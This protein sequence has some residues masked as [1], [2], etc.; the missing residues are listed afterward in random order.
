[1]NLR[2]SGLGAAALLFALSLASSALAQS[3]SIVG[4]VPAVENFDSLAS[5]G[6][7]DVLPPGW[8]FVESGTNANTTYAADNGGVNSGNTYS[9]GATGS[10]ERALGGLLSGSL[11][12][13]FGARLRN[14]SGSTLAEIAIEYTGEQWRLGALGREDRLD[15]QYSLDATSLATGTWTDV[16]ALDFVAP[17]TA[18]SIGALNGNDAAN[19]RLISG[20]ITGLNLAPEATLWIRWGDFNAS[21]ADDG[22]AIDDFSVAVP[23]DFPPQVIGSSPTQGATGVA[24]D[25]A[26][27]LLFSEAIVIADAA[28]IVLDCGAGTPATAAEA[29]GSTLS[30]T[31]AA[32]LSYGAA[33]SLAVA[34]DAVTDLDGT[35]DPMEQAF[36]LLFETVVD[37]PPALVSSVPADGAT[38][39]P[40]NANLQLVFSEPVTLGANWFA[41][42]CSQSGPRGPADVVLSGGPTEFSLNP[43]TDFIQGEN[44]TLTFDPSAIEDLDGV[45]DAL[46]DPGPIAFVP[47]APVLNQPPVVLSTTPMNGAN[48]FPPTAD[49]VVL[50]S[51]AV[52]LAPGAFSLSCV[53]S[54]GIALG[55]ATSGT[56][57]SIDTGTSLVAEDACVF[58]VHALAVE[59]SEGANLVADVVVS[60]LVR[61]SSTGAYYGQVN[62]SS[63]GQ[64]RCSL[65]EIIKGHTEYP[66]G[67]TQLEL[68]DEDPLDSSR[69]LDI[70]RNC[71]YAKGS[72][73]DRVGGSGSGATCGAISGLKFNREHVWP[74][75]LGFNNTS[76]AAHND[77]HMLHLSDE[78]FNANRGNKPFDYC[79]QSSGCLEDRTIAYAGQ[80]GGNGTYPGLSNWRTANDGNTGSYEVWSKLR[81]NMARALF[82]MAIRYEGGDNLPDLELTDNRSLI[83][84]LPS[85]AEKAYMGILTTLLEWHAQDP[86]DEREL[87]RNEIVFGFQGNRNPFVD[88][89]E[90]ATMALF[91]SSQPAE[92]ELGVPPNTP[93][94]A[95]AD[96]YQA[97]ESELL[98]VLAAEGVLAN[99]ADA[100]GDQLTAILADDVQHGIL[101]LAADGGFTYLPANGFCGSDGFTYR[102]NDGQDD[103]NLAAVSL[104]VACVNS[105]PQAFDDSY[106]ASEDETLTVLAAQGVLANDTDADGDELMAVLQAAPLH[107]ELSLFQDGGFIY[108]PDA[109]Y[110][111]PDA[112]SYRAADSQTQ[113]APAQVSIEVACVNDPPVATGTPEDLVLNE[114]QFMAA[115]DF[116]A[117]FADVD[118]ASLAFEAEGLPD[119]LAIS[120]EGLL[121]GTPSYGSAAGSP[122]AVTVTARDAAEA[123][124]SVS[125]QISVLAATPAEDAIFANGFED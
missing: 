74:R 4:G 25:T 76:L 86:V 44:C 5:N 115:V 125:L 7:S 85:S 31:P 66:Y 81:G 43:A 121:S 75:S 103:S 62:T 95:V 105:A 6:T 89:P 23:G 13:T 108:V 84:I 19:R 83:Q 114:G 70:Y 10:S 98:S 36:E 82:Y 39:F 35:P 26:I 51:E 102:A 92:C 99:D 93:P 41:I 71:S 104:D 38:D 34:A 97:T 8:F 113:S 79:P 61:S 120:A 57:F 64:L 16:N 3:V 117:L 28:G 45:A 20:S 33:C 109:D 80:G 52:M 77:L 87:Q 100:D 53:A 88:H 46:L 32:N 40:A 78:G 106:Q 65:H 50:F 42:A 1:M 110:C 63:P 15:F 60:F 48:D 68:A 69:I 59:D 72:T 30:V 122:Y 49:I 9:Y 21:G 96:S 118:D 47:A 90:W 29:I 58:T 119:G 54:T 124:A 11:T 18:G 24:V 123:S 94:V 27:W 91:T 116:A 14:D 37:D 111:G 2:F 22:L 56:S 55:H 17:T 67:W 107:G 73:G 112:F 101:A 12:P